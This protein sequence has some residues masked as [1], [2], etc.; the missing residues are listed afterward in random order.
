M[1]PVCHTRT[2]F[3]QLR[4]VLRLRVA[5]VFPPVPVTSR[6]DVSQGTLENEARRLVPH[7][8]FKKL[9]LLPLCPRR[10]VRKV[11]VTRH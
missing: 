6:L 2:H 8:R 7:V 1:A 4:V 9:K 3:A 10:R 11:A 5:D